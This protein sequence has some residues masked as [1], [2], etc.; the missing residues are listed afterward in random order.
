MRPARYAVDASTWIACAKHYPRPVFP[1]LVD[2][3]E[4][5]IVGGRM[6]S[7]AAAFGETMS[8]ND[9]VAQRARERR[10]VFAPPGDRMAAKAA[11]MPGDRP[12]LGRAR[13]RPRA[14]GKM[15]VLMARPWAGAAWA[16]ARRGRS[17]A[18]RRGS[19][20]RAG[21]WPPAA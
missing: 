7:P 5:L 10:P 6:V 17:R 4:K 11:P 21:A 16:A 8:G 3:C 18:A 14:S 9:E 19:P 12:S 15:L 1:T 13:G 20:R 2:Y